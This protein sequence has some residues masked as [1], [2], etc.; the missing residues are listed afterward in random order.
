MIIAINGGHTKSVVACYEAG[1][2]II[3]AG[4]SLNLHLFSHQQVSSRLDVLFTRL[5]IACGSKSNAALAENTERL[6]MSMPGAATDEEHYRVLAALTAAGWKRTENVFVVD[7]TWAGLVA[8]TNSLTGVCAMAGTGASVYVSPNPAETRF[9]PGKANKLDGWGW[10]IGDFGSG[11]QLAVD[12]FRELGRQIDRDPETQSLLSTELLAMEP[13]LS[14][15]HDV[16][17]WFDGLCSTDRSQHQ[18]VAHFAILASVVT[19]LADQ[20]QPD[21]IAH[22][23]IQKIAVEMVESITIALKRTNNSELRVVLQGGMFEHSKFYRNYVAEAISKTHKNP[24]ALAAYRPVFGALL[25]AC[26]DVTRNGEWK[27][28]PGLAQELHHVV[29]RSLNSE[30]IYHPDGLPPF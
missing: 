6:V 4:E 29:Q 12:M 28:V 14:S 18:W 7:D 13:D 9:H 5:R 26:A 10:I 21:G 22:S 25:L 16:Q 1:N 11:F 17:K 8:G 2:M 27:L 23:L 19:R 20:E 30:L 24:I 15:V 3:Q